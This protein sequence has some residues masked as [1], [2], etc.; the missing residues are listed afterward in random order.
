MQKFVKT[1]RKVNS[2]LFYVGKLKY[3]RRINLLAKGSENKGN[4]FVKGQT[5]FILQ[6]L[7]KPI[8]S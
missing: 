5:N 7:W 3:N 8:N 4:F 1:G 6:Y 2:K